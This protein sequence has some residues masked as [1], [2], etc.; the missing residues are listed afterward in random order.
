[1]SL[2]MADNAMR[3]LSIDTPIRVP[4][5]LPPW[6]TKPLPA[7]MMGL[8]FTELISRSMA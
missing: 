8:L 2:V 3:M 7:S 1:M 6:R 4:W 5:K